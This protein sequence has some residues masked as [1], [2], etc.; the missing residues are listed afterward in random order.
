MADI[1]EGD[2][3]YM[4][5]KYEE[6]VYFISRGY[7]IITSK[8]IDMMVWSPLRGA[9]MSYANLDKKTEYLRVKKKLE[10]DIEENS[11]PVQGVVACGLA[12]GDAMVG[13][14]RGA[15][16]KLIRAGSLCRRLN[17]DG[18]DFHGFLSLQFIRSEMETSLILNSVNKNRI[19]KIARRGLKIANRYGYKRH[20][21]IIRNLYDEI[22]N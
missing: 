7:K 1:Y 4:N 5:K 6:S 14:Y 18:D 17:S 11:V 12:M 13:D 9:A 19:D 3:D 16:K 21:N 8:A 22:R 2:L 10:A 20:S 15:E